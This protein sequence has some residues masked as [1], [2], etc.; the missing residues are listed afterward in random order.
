MV[1]GIE[2]V[3]FVLRTQRTPQ[4]SA[5]PEAKRGKSHLFSASGA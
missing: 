5:I 4:F 2:T 1:S 3:L